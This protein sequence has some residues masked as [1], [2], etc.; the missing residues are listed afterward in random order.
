MPG[1]VE[2]PPA[3]FGLQLLS[4]VGPFLIQ[5][6]VR[7]V[8]SNELSENHD[9][10]GYQGCAGGGCL[11]GSGTLEDGERVRCFIHPVRPAGLREANLLQN[12]VRDARALDREGQEGASPSGTE[13]A[14]QCAL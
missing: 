4:E 9:D 11:V 1:P 6:T 8:L 3:D 5:E 12:R 13:P 7:G 14:S 2:I 10:L